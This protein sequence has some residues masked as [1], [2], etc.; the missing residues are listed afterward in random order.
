MSSP[1]YQSIEADDMLL[2][3]D[4]GAGALLRVIAG[5]VDGHAGP[6]N[7]HTPIT[8]IHASVKPGTTVTLPWPAD[9]N[10]LAYG[11]AGSG[12][13]GAE[14]AAFGTGRLVAFGGGDI[15]DHHRGRA[16]GLPHRRSR[17]AAAR[18]RADR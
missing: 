2:L 16:T 12:T 17:G 7:T 4:A 13:A 15:G 3:T 5:D 1:R 9:F 14:G 10:A 6:G 8:V 18:R 11:L